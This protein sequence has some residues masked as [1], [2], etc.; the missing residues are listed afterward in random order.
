MEVKRKIVCMII[1]S[2]F[3][4]P[5]FS[6]AQG[7]TNGQKN[8]DVFS[9][10][11]EYIE[12]EMKR[13]NLPGLAL[14]I[15]EDDRIIYLKGYGHA[16][17]SGRPVTPETPFGIGSIGKSL[18][19]MAVLQLVEQG[20]IDLDAPIQQYI[21]GFQEQENVNTPDI[22]VRQLLNQTSGFTQNLT[23]KNTVSLP[24]G[25]DALE[26]NALSYTK[27]FLHQGDLKEPVY[28]YSNAN[29]VLLGYVIQQVSGKS[30]IDYIKEH[31]FSPLS[32][33]NS[34]VTLEEAKENGLATPYRRLFGWNVAY[35][36]PY[37]Y[38]P[39]DLPAGYQYSSAKD[40]SHYLIAQM[41]GGQFEDDN[42]LS[43]E[44]VQLM[45]TEPVP[46]TYAM[47]WQSSN[48]DGLPV[49]GHP[50]G[51]I[52]YQ[53]Q[54]FIV[55]EQKLGVIVFSNVLSAIDAALPQTEVIT[56]THIASGVV[57]LL[58]DQPVAE[59]GLSMTQKY[60]LV[61]GVMLLFTVWL[62]YLTTRTAKHSIRRINDNN[63][64]KIALIAKIIFY[65]TIPI[66][67]LILG[68]TQILPIWHMATIYQLDVILWVKIMAVILALNGI[69]EVIYWV[70]WTKQKNL[71]ELPKQ[72]TP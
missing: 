9:D 54:T 6:S 45:Q 37:I 58:T 72:A 48:I 35:N 29:Y 2:L 51:L 40:M 8:D 18:T 5:I 14:G 65:F 34:F 38:I 63:F 21:P 44:S 70:R 36:G 71:S 30:Y 11:D 56:T 13:Q 59:D 47:G 4:I 61:D 57:N 20:R 53:A 26:K 68:M 25:P 62:L 3:I 22:T 69:M 23:F 39:G 15:V 50:G 28:R 46:G 7:E 55:P 33:E 1:C 41:N 32:M 64:S 10:V 49:I 12:R 43:P 24:N 52:G 16:D 67:V 27:N 31:I 60:L 19:A 42:V 17:S 66:L